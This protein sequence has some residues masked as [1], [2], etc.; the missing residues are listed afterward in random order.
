[1]GTEIGENKMK[2][3]ACAE[4]FIKLIIKK[5][6][7]RRK[8]RQ[9][10][11]Q[12]LTAH[13]EDELK[14]CKTDEE[15]EQKAKQLIAGFGDVKLLAVLLRRAKKRCR[16]LWRIAL[17]RS[18]Q[19]L[20]IIILYFLICSLPLLVGRPTIS[21]NYVNWLNDLVQAGR[22]EADNA[23]PF[24]EKAVQLYVENPQWLDK[25]RAV[26]VTDLNDVELKSLSDWLQSNQG[27]FKVL[28]Q[29]SRRPEFWNEY[30]SDETKL[31]KDHLGSPLTATIL[32]SNT[33][34]I[35]SAY[36]SLA[37]AMILKLH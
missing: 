12:E 23:R 30:Q 32:V 1:M 11:Q 4:E 33:M 25:N 9:D 7:Y 37:R 14:N 31:E 16:P 15:K 29:G 36:K 8:L 21:V 24:Y 10:V 28:R 3:P 2:L 5:M 17:V 19:V 22:N 13:F 27:A 6:R 18:F 35:L 34:E 20:G 26:W